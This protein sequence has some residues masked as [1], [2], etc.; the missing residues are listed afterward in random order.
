MKRRKDGSF[1]V[2]VELVE[3][4]TY[5]YRF[6]LDGGRWENDWDAQEYAPNEHGTEDS[7]LRL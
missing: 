3:G 4:R 2:K 7:V 5:R 1:R 6:L